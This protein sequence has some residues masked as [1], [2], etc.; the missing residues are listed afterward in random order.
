MQGSSPN[1]TR[2]LGDLAEQRAEKHLIEHGLVLI[3]RNFSCAVGEIDLLMR[4]KKQLVF[5]EVRYRNSPTFGSA[6]ETVTRKK[7]K[8][9]IAAAQYYLQKYCK[10]VDYRFDVVGITH[11][12]LH[13]VPSAFPGI[14]P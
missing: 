6:L 8:K 13:W 10:S 11:N 7:Q 14:E 4:D 1:N 3:D 5:V 12:E 2:A 9:I